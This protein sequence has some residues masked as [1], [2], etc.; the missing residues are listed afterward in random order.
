G[1]QIRCQLHS[2]RAD[3]QRKRAT[4][5]ASG[6]VGPR[7]GVGQSHQSSAGNCLTVNSKNQEPNSKKLNG[8]PAFGIWFLDFVWVHHVEDGFPISGTRGTK[9]GDGKASL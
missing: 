2:A 5:G 6:W 9:P 8:C 4:A 1:D 7:K 3:F